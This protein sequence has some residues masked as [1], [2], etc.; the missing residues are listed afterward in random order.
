MDLFDGH[1]MDGRF[2][3]G[4]APEQRL[5][6]VPALFRQRGAIDQPENLEQASMFMAVG[7]MVVVPMIVAVRRIWP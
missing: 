1:L 2:R 4:Q 5:R 7:I 6:A 3:L